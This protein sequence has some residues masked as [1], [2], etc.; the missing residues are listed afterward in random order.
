[1]SAQSRFENHAITNDWA[2]GSIAQLLPLL[3]YEHENGDETASRPLRFWYRLNYYMNTPQPYQDFLN[4]HLSN[5]HKLSFQ[6]LDEWWTAQYQEPAFSTDARSKETDRAK[7]AIMRGPNTDEAMF[8]RTFLVQ[9]LFHLEHSSSSSNLAP[10]YKDNKYHNAM[11]RL[12]SWEFCNLNLEGMLKEHVQTVE[13]RHKQRRVCATSAYWQALSW[14]V[15]QR[16]Q[17]DLEC[18]V[19]AAPKPQTADWSFLEIPSN[20]FL[21]RGPILAPCPWLKR[22][23]DR[24]ENMPHYLWDVQRGLTVKTSHGFTPHYVAISHTWGRYVK[25][26]PWIRVKGVPWDIPQNT[27][28]EVGN[29]DQILSLV[30]GGLDFVWFDLVCIPQGDTDTDTKNKEISRQAEIFRGAKYAVAWLNTI[31]NLNGLYGEMAVRALQSL[32]FITHEGK[33]QQSTAVRSYQN[34]LSDLGTGLFQPRPHGRNPSEWC[35]N[36]WFTSLWTLQEVCLRPDMWICAKD[37]I[38][39]TSDGIVP[40]TISGFAIR[41]SK[42]AAQAY[43]SV[44][45]IEFEYWLRQTGFDTFGDLDQA[46]IMSLGDRRE[47]TGRRAEAIMSVVG[48]TQWYTD[49]LHASMSFEKKDTKDLEGDL[50]LGKYPIAFVN[51]LARK[52]PH[53]FFG[54]LAKWKMPEDPSKMGGLHGRAKDEIHNGSMLPFSC[55]RAAYMN[56]NIGRKFGHFF[57]PVPSIASWFVQQ[58]GTVRMPRTTLASSS[59]MS[60]Q[61]PSHNIPVD[62]FWPLNE[63]VA[64]LPSD[65]NIRGVTFQQSMWNDLHQWIHRRPN[66]SHA[67]I[68]QYARMTR[69]STKMWPLC[70]GVILERCKFGHLRKI[71]NFLLQDVGEIIDLTKEEDV[72]WV[73]A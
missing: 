1:M 70:F 37:W 16:W 5:E 14:R 34:V 61:I 62:L 59:T 58:D 40:I 8:V 51:E 67:V 60:N 32:R 9:H 71:G 30:P 39:L 64:P 65:L 47:C 20:A 7:V 43:E 66:E 50:V 63:V 46:S 53:I 26:E 27:C 11:L 31:E 28:F 68:T 6:L 3:P 41:P 21:T 15:Y 57:V 18:G 23:G 42:S 49:A 72:D 69:L 45:A 73:V 12:Y 29:I 38:Y 4:K 13:A 10:L 19:D 36:P 56:H 24:L 52:S 17:Q 25:A 54:T 55:Y 2:L 35:L 48:A 22:H 33:Q 44:S